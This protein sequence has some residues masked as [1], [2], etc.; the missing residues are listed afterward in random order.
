[1]PLLTTAEDL[2]LEAEMLDELTD[3]CV[4]S[5]IVTVQTSDGE[6]RVKSPRGPAVACAYGILSGKE[7][8]RAQQV[9]P[10]ATVAL[11]LPKSTVVTAADVID[12]TD[13]LTAEV[14]PVQVVFVGKA[15][16]R[17]WLGVYATLY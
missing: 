3:S 2:D 5:E 12:I 9:A 10:E 1:M 4:I 15:T 17:S 8:D 16:G 7:L 13:A 14:I 6:T 11:T